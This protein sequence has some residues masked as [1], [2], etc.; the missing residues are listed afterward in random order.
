MTHKS[1][2]HWGLHAIREEAPLAA[3]VYMLTLAGP[4]QANGQRAVGSAAIHPDAID[5]P[6][7]PYI[8]ALQRHVRK[9]EAGPPAFIRSCDPRLLERLG[10]RKEVC[11]AARNQINEQGVS[12]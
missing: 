2:S 4:I 3:D 8:E 5:A 10:V 9:L 6:L 12:E 11:E 1:F 7:T